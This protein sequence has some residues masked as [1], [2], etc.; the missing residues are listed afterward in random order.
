M[1]HQNDKNT[2][3]QQRTNLAIFASG[4]GS[5]AEAIIHYSYRTAAAF[6][7]A[8]VL[9]NNSRCGA[10]ERA[11]MF[12]IPTM[13]I[14]SATHPNADDYAQAIISAL[15]EHNV[16]MIALAGFMKKIPQEVVRTFSPKKRSR[17]FNIHPS[18]LPKFGGHEMYGINVHR[19]V[20]AAQ[21]PESGCTVHEVDGDYDT[22]T[23]IAQKSIAV[24]SSDTPESLAARILLYEH[25]L[26]PEVLQQKA[27]E[28]QNDRL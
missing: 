12:N 22:G 17:V 21:E 20:V 14:S 11:M 18:L 26:Y 28:I 13:H 19:A 16:E 1:A 23:I 6:R 5:N 10:M 9:S 24:L 15:Q 8:L 2:A 7:V 4:G 25:E 3:Q 27:Q